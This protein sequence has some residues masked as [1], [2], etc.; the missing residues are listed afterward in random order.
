MS[1]F[2]RSESDGHVNALGEVE[3]YVVTAPIRAQAFH[4]P[5]SQALGSRRKKH[6]G[7]HCHSASA[8]FSIAAATSFA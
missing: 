8:A 6:R 4:I 2:S 3:Q 1:A 5:Q 7:Q